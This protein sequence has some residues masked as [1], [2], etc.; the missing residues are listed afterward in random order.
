MRRRG[1]AE[2]TR[3]NCYFLGIKGFASFTPTLSWGIDNQSPINQNDSWLTSSYTCSLMCE[4]PPQSTCQLLGGRFPVKLFWDVMRSTWLKRRRRDGGRRGEGNDG[5][6]RIVSSFLECYWQTWRRVKS[7][8]VAGK[9]TEH[10]STQ[11][12]TARAQLH[13]ITLTHNF[14]SASSSCEYIY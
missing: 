3:S 7:P 11:L 5:W 14:H 2:T 6:A 9:L 12:T 1:G 10:F 4:Q 8:E 13:I